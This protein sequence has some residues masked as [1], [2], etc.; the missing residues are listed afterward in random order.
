MSSPLSSAEAIGIGLHKSYMKFRLGSGTRA[1]GDGPSLTARLPSPRKLHVSLFQ[2]PLRR[3]ECHPHS[4]TCNDPINFIE[5]HLDT[6]YVC[7]DFSQQS[8]H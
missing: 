8:N 3:R 4:Y 1:G 5:S 7:I 6:S 2:S